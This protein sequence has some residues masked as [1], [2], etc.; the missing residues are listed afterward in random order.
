M[1]LK[2]LCLL[3]ITTCML[4]LGV[5]PARALA[6]ER[7][8][9]IRQSWDA[10]RERS[11]QLHLKLTSVRVETPP[12]REISDADR[13]AG[14]VGPRP[15]RLTTDMWFSDDRI[16]I[17]I[18]RDPKEVPWLPTKDYY[19]HTAEGSQYIH[20]GTASHVFD[21]RSIGGVS[22][23]Q[24]VARF[25]LYQVF[26]PPMLSYR[27]A[28]AGAL[29]FALSSAVIDKE[30]RKIG[31]VDCLVLIL[32][33]KDQA[34]ITTEVWV[35]PDREFV[36]LR[37]LTRRNQVLTRQFDA[38]FNSH[39]TIGYALAAWR[40]QSMKSNGELSAS[41]DVTVQTFDAEAPIPDAQFRIQ[42]P[43]GA[44]VS[45][46]DGRG[47]VQVG[48]NGEIPGFGAGCNAD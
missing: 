14:R 23:K 17:A 33:E 36:P 29:S 48:P 26:F 43:P 44:T 10:R 31:D 12:P 35:D 42:F 41:E 38:T 2:V 6:D 25:G 1:R 24:R 20:T 13:A 3:V 28:E 39:P 21:A 16:A 8:E 5:D 19:V 32:K 40:F 47:R 37:I 22:E 46:D 34:L 30:V 4:P 27:A 15:H 7:I 11:K 18:E 9:Q 45:I